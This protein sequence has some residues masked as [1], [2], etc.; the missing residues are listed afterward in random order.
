MNWSNEWAA[1]PS[2]QTRVLTLIKEVPTQVPA[3]VVGDLAV[4]C[5]QQ[6]NWYITHLPTMK[7][8]DMA[9]PSGSRDEKDLIAWCDAV[10]LIETEIWDMLHRYNHETINDASDAV[11]EEIDRLKDKCLAVRIGNDGGWR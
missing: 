6:V 11:I 2:R 9:L 7:K 3:I 10:Q 5:G 4:H 8:F 1:I